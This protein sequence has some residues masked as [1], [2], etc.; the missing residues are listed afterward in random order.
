MRIHTGFP[1]FPAGF[2]E[3]R[4]RLLRKTARSRPHAFLSF[5]PIDGYNGPYD[6]PFRTRGAVAQAPKRLPVWH[7]RD[8][9][10]PFGD[11]PHNGRR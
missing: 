11:Y 5:I 10:D 9:F 7:G 6:Q 2:G 1:V 8:R 4:P 3:G